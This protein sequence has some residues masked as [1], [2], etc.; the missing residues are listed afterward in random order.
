[1]NLNSEHG[2]GAG[3]FRSD[4]VRYRTVWISDLHLGARGSSAEKLIDFLK[5]FECDKLYVVGDFIDL[6]QLRKHRYWPQSHNDVIQKI[7]GKARRGTAVIYIPGNHDDF[8]VNFFGTY[9]NIRVAEN[10]VHLTATGKRLLILHGHE[11]DSVTQHAKW[12]A[13]VGDVGYN[14]L[15]KINY[16]LNVFRRL[17][18]FGY[19]SLSAYVKRKV[20]NAV[21]VISDF[22]DMV[23]KYAQMHNASGIVCG[24]IHTPS[25]REIR[26]IQYYNCGDW[27]ESCTALVEYPDGVLE[28]VYQ[29][30]KE[31]DMAISAPTIIAQPVS[32]PIA[33]M[34]E[35]P[36]QPSSVADSY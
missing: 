3:Q 17:F 10:D 2:A 7:L 28:L 31:G 19:W 13:I 23:A 15:L 8:I 20:K 26:G 30:A 27:V 33:K 5:S 34:Q 16:L 9:G 25:V 36:A 29:K 12:L 11:F 22:E 14:M 21:N 1:M 4:T 18:G 24:H 32:L 35:K 6:W